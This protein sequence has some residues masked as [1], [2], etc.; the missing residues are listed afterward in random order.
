ME[1][2]RARESQ[3]DRDS[4]R[5]QFLSLSLSLFPPTHTKTQS[6]P[7]AE[8]ARGDVHG[9]GRIRRTTQLSEGSDRILTANLQ[10]N[11]VPTA[12]LIHHALHS[13]VSQTSRR[14]GQQSPEQTD[15]QTNAA[16]HVGETTASPH[17]PHRL[18]PP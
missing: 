11:A 15:K 10:G 6:V 13:G 5:V 1:N 7:S 16:T 8:G 12:Q 2:G 4:V 3:L 17:S 14:G 18:T 9:N